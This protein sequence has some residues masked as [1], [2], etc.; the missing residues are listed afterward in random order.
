M[1][2]YGSNAILSGY[3]S[4]IIIVGII[5]FFSTAFFTGWLAGKKGY[6]IG[7]WGILGF[8]F[9][10]I[11]VLAVGFAPN[12]F[13]TIGVTQNN[14]TIEKDWICKKCSNINSVTALFC[15]SCGEKK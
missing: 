10:F 5:Y 9:G 15:N 3:I 11:A 12:N 2:N 14:K 1:G 8:F 7:L 6:S 4:L 13:N